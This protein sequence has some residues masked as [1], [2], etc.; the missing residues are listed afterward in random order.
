MTAH[1]TGQ[2]FVVVGPSGAGKDTLMAG[3]SAADPCLHWARRVITRPETA[4]GEPFEGTDEAGFDARL[5]RGDFALHWQAHRLRY[6]V[7]AAELAPLLAGR[8]VMVNGSRAALPAVQ[9]A[10]P[11]LVVIRVSAPSAVL[12]ARLAARGR[13]S[14]TDIAARLQRA[15]YDLPD[16]LTV[17]EVV[18]DATPQIGIERLRTAIYSVKA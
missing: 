14:L 11:G 10:Y 15:S 5:T 18:N 1:M 8:S 12:A 6:G 4:G 3:A 2:L 16:G 7:T 17:L 9:G 13:E